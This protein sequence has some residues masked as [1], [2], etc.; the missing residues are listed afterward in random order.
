MPDFFTS[1]LWKVFLVTFSVAAPILILSFFHEF[2][3]IIV[4]SFVLMIVLR[5]I[6]DYAE[7]KGLVRPAAILA[8]YV[9]IGALVAVGFSTV[10]PIVVGQAAVLSSAFD[11]AHMDVITGNAAKSI[12]AFVPALKVSQIATKLNAL[13]AEASGEAEELLTDIIPVAASMVLVPLVSFFLLNDYHKM[14]KSF[15]QKIPN[16]YFEMTLNVVHKL[17]VQ[18]SNY[19][20]GLCLEVIIVALLYIGAYSV[21]GIK[22]A[23]IFGIVGG[24]MNLIPIVGPVVAVVPVIVVSLFQRGDLSMLLPIVGIVF[25]VQQTDVIFIQPN[26][27]GKVLNVHPLTIIFAVLIGSELFGIPGTIL[28][29]PIYTIISV[30]A[31]ETNWGLKHYTITH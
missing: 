18:L 9:V 6:V 26:I 20:R 7:G 19:I 31:R 1:R 29:I 3:L 11:N 30:T 8:L 5:P 14:Q 16:K 15:I 10:Y 22:Y 17:E 13:L 27:Y 23:T 28:A 24:M 12:S 21:I 4:L 25:V 2:F